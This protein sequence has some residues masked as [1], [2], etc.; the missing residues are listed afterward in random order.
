MDR[1]VRRRRSSGAHRTID[2]DGIWGDSNYDMILSDWREVGGVQFA[3]DQSFTLNGREVQHIQVEDVVPNPVLGSDLFK[4]PAIV[5][6]TAATQKAPEQVNYQW[7][8]RRA[9][10]GSFIDS[11]QTRL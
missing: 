4:I 11:D 9:N 10:W 1:A 3:F 2:A 6:A 7:M 5:T 8:L